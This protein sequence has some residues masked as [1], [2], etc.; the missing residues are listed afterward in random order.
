M[1]CVFLSYLISTPPPAHKP[2]Q[3]FCDEAFFFCLFAWK[4]QK[5]QLTPDPGSRESREFLNHELVMEPHTYYIRARNSAD[6]GVCWLNINQHRVAQ[7]PS[8]LQH[9]WSAASQGLTWHFPRWKG[10]HCAQSCERNAAIHCVSAV[11][12]LQGVGICCLLCCV[13]GFFGSFIF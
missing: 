6:S 2:T 12:F 3:A 10:L 8:I 7:T 13:A 5:L 1:L 11:F 4:N 9:L